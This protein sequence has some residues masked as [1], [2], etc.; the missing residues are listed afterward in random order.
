MLVWSFAGALALQAGIAEGVIG[1]GVA[2]GSLVGAATA[3]AAMRE[4]VLVPLPAT[5]LISG[6]MIASPV[7][8]IGSGSANLF[9]I[10]I[11]LLNVGS[12]TMII[13]CS[14]LATAANLAP[15]FR[16]FVACTHSLGMIAGPA[17]GSVLI[18]GFGYQGLLA[19]VITALATG[20]IAI[21]FA[22]KQGFDIA[23]PLLVTGP[24]ILAEN[25]PQSA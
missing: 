4:R 15:R 11:T 22:L 18:A 16:T 25:S 17:A 7:L 10:S 8:L 21:F 19:G 14:G 3:L 20:F 1:E 24:E 2:F 9:I 6:G 23:S 13:R 5:A 12:T